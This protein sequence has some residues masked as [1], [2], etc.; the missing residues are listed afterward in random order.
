MKW[1]LKFRLRLNR[2]CLIQHHNRKKGKKNSGSA[3]GPITTASGTSAILRRNWR[4]GVFYEHPAGPGLTIPLSLFIVTLTQMIMQKKTY[5]Y[6]YSVLL[7]FT[8]RFM[9]LV[10]TLSFIAGL[11]FVITRFSTK[12]L[13]DF[14]AN[15]VTVLL[16]LYFCVYWSDIEMDDTAMY[17]DFSGKWITIPWADVV[18]VGQVKNIIGFEIWYIQVK[19]LNFVYKLLG[20]VNIGSFVPVIL[21]LHI[22]KNRK[23]LIHEIQ[24]RK[25]HHHDHSS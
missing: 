11:Y 17:I 8:P 13:T 2:L 19:Q 12:I 23:E 14:L 18:K 4:I 5:K 21:V 10:F 1:T 25:P 3:W 24:R 7:K 20:L 6:P 22:L 16:S 9:L 15:F